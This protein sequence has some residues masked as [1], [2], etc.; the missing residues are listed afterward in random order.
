MSSRS[1]R[2]RRRLILNLA[3]YAFSLAL[4][5]WLATGD[6]ALAIFVLAGLALS[7]GLAVIGYRR[8]S[9]SSRQ[10]RIN[11]FIRTTQDRAGREM[12]GW[13]LVLVMGV[14]GVVLGLTL[15]NVWQ[16]IWGA[17]YAAQSAFRLSR[18]G[19]RL[20]VRWSA[21]DPIVQQVLRRRR[22]MRAAPGASPNR[23]DES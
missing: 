20:G 15:G 10:K 5:A 22:A 13:W 21:Q 19:E 14:T 1:N 18:V 9:R 4:L 6:V 3:C 11:Q 16:V 12:W 8:Y 23:P 7:S 2:T 17:V